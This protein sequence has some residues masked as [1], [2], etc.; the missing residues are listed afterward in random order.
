MRNRTLM[1]GLAVLLASLGASAFEAVTL[2][3][4]SGEEIFL[5]YCAACHG[6]SGRGDGPVARGL[7]TAVPDLTAISR[8]YGEFPA[9][10]IADTIDGRGA[11]VDA[12]GNRTMPVWGYEFW[13]EEGG[14]VVAQREMK[15]VIANLVE[16][17]RSIQEGTRAQNAE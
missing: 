11:R 13:V 12:H 5:K 7:V 14:D 9:M 15:Q 6:E 2:V 10:R 8:R 17:I 4:Y 1:V 16:Y 3:D